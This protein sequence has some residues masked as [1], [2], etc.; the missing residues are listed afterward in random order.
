MRYVGAMMLGSLKFKENNCFEEKY[1]GSREGMAL[2]VLW[3]HYPRIR[4]APYDL[5]PETS[6]VC[7]TWAVLSS[8]LVGESCVDVLPNNFKPWHS[9]IIW[10][11]SNK[12]NRSKVICNMPL[13]IHSHQFSFMDCSKEPCSNTCFYDTNY[14][15]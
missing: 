4:E 14:W 7:I 6:H 12:E 13:C 2:L 11:H 3:D 15:W 10:V 8:V 5:T 9:S 1:S